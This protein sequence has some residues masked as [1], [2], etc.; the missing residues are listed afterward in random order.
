MSDTFPPCP[1]AESAD[2]PL[3]AYAF[4]PIATRSS[5]HDGWTAERQRKFVAA[6]AAM[7]SVARAAKSVGMGITSAYNLRRRAGA[8]SF[9]AA[10]DAALREGQDR[11]FDR[12]MERAVHGYWMPRFYRDRIVGY[13]HRHDDAMT[14]A[15]LR[16][17][18]PPAALEPEA[19]K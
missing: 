2:E 16:Y 5:R 4:T 17:A 7:G 1:A 3:P 15:A 8:E 10:W 18:M 11:A 19:P 6:L 12:A 9:A 13:F 14:A